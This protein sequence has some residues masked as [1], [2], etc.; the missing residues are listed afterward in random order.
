MPRHEYGNSA[1]ERAALAYGLGIDRVFHSISYVYVKH[2]QY[3]KTAGWR[4][5]LPEHQIG[6]FGTFLLRIGKTGQIVLRRDHTFERLCCQT[7]HEIPSV[8][9]QNITHSDFALRTHFSDRRARGL[10]QKL[11]LPDHAVWKTPVVQLYTFAGA[12]AAL[13]R[14]AHKLVKHISE[15]RKIYPSDGF[16]RAPGGERPSRGK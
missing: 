4:A 12:L 14:S 7:F 15:V 11:I 9:R 2:C 6:G 10:Q 13:Q 16:S 8:W 3:R 1:F 5:Y